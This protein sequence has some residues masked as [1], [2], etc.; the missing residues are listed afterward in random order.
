MMKRIT[1][2]VSLI[3]LLIFAAGF[4]QPVLAISQQEIKTANSKLLT[5]FPDVRI[6]REDDGRITRVFGKQMTNGSSPTEAAERFKNEYAAMFG[7]DPVDLRNESFLQS[8]IKTLPLMYNKDTGEYKFTM[9][10]FS[11]YEND[12]P[13]HM[14]DLRVLV[15]NQPGYRSYGRDRH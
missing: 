4:I 2:F 9:V 5:D 15:L 1:T 11:Q 14:S 7:V 13:V 6:Y 10:Y 12:L 8:G 3:T